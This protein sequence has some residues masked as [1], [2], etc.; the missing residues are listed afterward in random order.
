[1]SNLKNALSKFHN[2]E[3]GNESLQTVAILA[4]GAIVLIALMS[5]WKTGVREPT[6]QHLET[7]MGTAG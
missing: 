2:D 5:V 3:T 1:M 7:L 4:V 6:E